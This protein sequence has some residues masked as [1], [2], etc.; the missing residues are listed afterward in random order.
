MADSGRLTILHT[1]DFHGMAKGERL[2]RL[3]EARKRAN[4]YFDCGDAIQA[5]NLAIPL[6]PDPVWPALGELR[7]SASVPGNRESHIL[8]LGLNA[9]LNGLRHPI[10][11]ANW[12]DREGNLIFPP[13]M[14]AFVNRHRIGV[15]GVMLP[16]V[17]PNM[18]TSAA[19][20]FLWSSP[21][22]AAQTV[23]AELTEEPEVLIALTHLGLRSDRELADACPEIDLIL[24][25]HSH[26]ILDPPEVRGKT[27][28]GQVGSHARFAGLYTW[29]YGRG[30][31]DFELI[32]LA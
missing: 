20:A 9:K 30:L 17:T 6:S 15:F 3:R 25:G 27:V 19:S 22:I 26:D 32:P 10:L 11:C 21:I 24:G 23:M 7:C 29:E 5:G 2:E 12:H 28:I 31:V 8:E 4:L 16:M 13:T 18:R 1:N 14:S